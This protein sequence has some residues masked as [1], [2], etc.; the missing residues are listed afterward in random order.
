MSTSAAPPLDGV[1]VVFVG[2]AV[3]VSA[4]GQDNYD[5]AKWFLGTESEVQLA[6]KEPQS[7]RTSL[8]QWANGDD[9]RQAGR[10]G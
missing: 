1:V 3:N 4:N 2:V 5:D 9:D 8:S 6:R 10:Q 7:Q